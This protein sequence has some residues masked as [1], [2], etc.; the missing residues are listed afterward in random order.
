V[1]VSSYSYITGKTVYIS[2]SRVRVYNPE[3]GID[4]Y[5][6]TNS[7]GNAI[8]MGS[9]V[10]DSIKKYQVTATK[11]DYETIETKPPFPETSYDPRDM[12]ASVVTNTGTPNY[13]YIAQNKMADDLKISTIDYLD[14]PIPSVKFDIVGGRKMGNEHVEPRDIIYNMKSSETTNSSGEKDF[15]SVSP[16]TYT[17]SLSSLETNFE[18]IGIDPNSSFLLPSDGSIN[19]KMK[20]AKKNETSL[21]VK[22]VSDSEGN[23]LISGAEVK[24]SNVGGYDATQTSNFQGNVF[25]PKTSDVFQD[26]T[27][28]L[29]ITADGFQE[30]N[31]Q[32]IIDSGALKI[33]PAVLTGL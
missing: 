11:D 1:N 22:V 23:P 5:K 15:G 16:G 2:D 26:G 33:E 28:D 4:V 20:L 19:L 18:I 9:N 32:V 24:L 25:F 27:Y 21:L 14:Q 13:A 30:K 8:F 7:S 6:Y 29:K 3:T 17:V 31:S 10:S 12:H